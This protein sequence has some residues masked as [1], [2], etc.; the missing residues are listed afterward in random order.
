MFF[1][2]VNPSLLSSIHIFILN[3]QLIPAGSDILLNMASVL[4]DKTV[5]EEPLKFRPERYLEGDVAKKKQQ[6][7]PF[8][9]GT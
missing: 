1:H 7:L 6:T 5:F 8:G 2:V 9:L 3:T 4:H